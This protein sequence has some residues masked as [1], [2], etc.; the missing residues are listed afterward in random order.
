MAEQTL[1]PVKRAGSVSL[2]VLLTLVLVLVAVI[3]SIAIFIMDRL[4]K[5]P[6]PLDTPTGELGFMSNRAGNWDILTISPAGTV[7]NLTAEGDYDDYFASWSFSGD[8]VNFLTNRTG[9]IGAGQVQPDGDGLRVLG[10]TEAIRSVFLEGR[11]DW[12]P[13]WSPDG[14]RVVFASLRD[15]NLEL[16][17]MDADSNN[18]TRLTDGAARDWFMVWS[19]DGSRIAFSSDRAGNE[20]IYVLHLEDSSVTQL[21]TDEADDMRP[22]WS[23]DGQRILFVSERRGNMLDAGQLDLY[24][25]NAD[26]SDQRPLA[27]GE[28]FV[29]GLT[30]SDNGR[31]VAFMSNEAGDWNIYV[32]E[33]DGSSVRRM[34]A[35]AAEDMYPVWRPAPAAAEEE[36]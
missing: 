29:G 10:V 14:S 35:S 15:L 18:L 23:R 32:M 6:I 22:I 19:P 25:M 8:M 30:Y 7:I 1:P 26:G 3:G 24:I 12:D 13:W 4:N 36:E 34:T 31:Q 20:D 11:L 5:D 2:R 17:V 27:E 16:Y 28:I 21:T 9:E 33:A